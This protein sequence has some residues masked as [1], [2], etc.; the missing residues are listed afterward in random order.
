MKILLTSK[1]CSPCNTI[2]AL[3]IE[4][5]LPVRIVDISDELA[6]SYLEKFN[7]RSVPAL[8]EGESVFVGLNPIMEKLLNG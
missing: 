7:V 4:K 1:N 3:I 6:K 8:V 5:E 2:K